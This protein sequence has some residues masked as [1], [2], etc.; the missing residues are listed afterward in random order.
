ME[1]TF[2]KIA[3][4]I[5]KR[6]EENIFDN[7]SNSPDTENDSSDSINS[8]SLLSILKLA[9]INEEQT[10][11]EIASTGNILTDIE[12]NDVEISDTRV[13]GY[14]NEDKSEF[15]FLKEYIAVIDKMINDVSL[16]TQQHGRHLK[17]QALCSYFDNSIMNSIGIN[18]S[19]PLPKFDW[20]QK[21][22]INVKILKGLRDEDP[23][24][25]NILRTFLGLLEDEKEIFES[26]DSLKGAAEDDADMVKLNTGVVFTAV[27]L[28]NPMPKMPMSSNT[29]ESN[30][31]I[32]L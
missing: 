8:E 12:L 22:G 16:K 27:L 31:K 23:A 2:H 24:Y 15:G 25:K 30:F 19:R 17:D 4:Y 3:E 1:H 9:Y 32:Q 11:I 6:I 14:N 26:F 13:Y 18:G 28:F 20:S 5:K 7:D 10:A 21:M 29:T